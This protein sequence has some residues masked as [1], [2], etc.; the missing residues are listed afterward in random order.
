M[1]ENF[2]GLSL[3]LN[4][5]HPRNLMIGCGLYDELVSLELAYATLTTATGLSNATS[6]VT[7]GSFSDGSARKP[8]LSATNHLFE[9]SDTT[10]VMQSVDWLGRSLQGVAQFGQH[11]LPIS[12]QIY[13]YAN[14]AGLVQ[15]SALLFS[16]FPVYLI[17]YSIHYEIIYRQLP[18]IE[19]A[20][21]VRSEIRCTIQSATPYLSTSKSYL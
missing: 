6:D 19:K 17:A 21:S 2:G 14:L 18:V 15:T 7:Y 10:I 5:T 13:Q 4:Q 8:V 20:A 9:I 1:G 12:N 11:T 16:I 3:P